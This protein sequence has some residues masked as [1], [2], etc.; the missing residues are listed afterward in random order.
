VVGMPRRRNPKKA[1]CSLLRTI[2]REGARPP[3]KCRLSRG[4][5]FRA[6]LTP[7]CSGSNKWARWGISPDLADGWPGLCA[8][9][10]GAGIAKSG[11]H[12]RPRAGPRQDRSP[13]EQ[14]RGT[15]QAGAATVGCFEV[16][17]PRQLAVTGCRVTGWRATGVVATGCTTT[18]VR[19]VTVRVTGS[20]VPGTGWATGWFTG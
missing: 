9:Q 18:G 10:A 1:C 7:H 11:G 17:K 19:T 6:R 4:H 2:T 12:S 3:K 16:R 5:D 20:R 15:A 13:G 14:D 8:G